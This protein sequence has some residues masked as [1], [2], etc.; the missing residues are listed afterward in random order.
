MK[1][2]PRDSKEKA[3]FHG[4]LTVLEVTVIT[5]LHFYIC[6]LNTRFCV[7]VFVG[8]VHHLLLN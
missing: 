1:L 6:H 3:A 8:Q 7:H 5:S 4:F 2:P